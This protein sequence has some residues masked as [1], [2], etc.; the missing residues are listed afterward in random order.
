MK[1][2]T[3]TIGLSLATLLAA[4]PALAHH[5]MGGEVP[6]T[7]W[8]GLLSGFGHPVIGIDHLAFV[9]AI[10]LAAEPKLLMLDEP[11]T[12]IAPTRVEAIGNLIRK[13]NDR[14]ITICVIEH[15]VKLLTGLCDRMVALNFGQKMADGPPDE[16]VNDPN[17]IQAYLGA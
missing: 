6:Q 7:F 4:T 15:N 8:H 17:V 2:F 1:R 3:K 13:A 10:G 16:V 12:G 14:G 5:P 11:I 9:V